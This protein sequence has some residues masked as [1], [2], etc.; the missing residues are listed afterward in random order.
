MADLRNSQ[1]ISYKAT[2]NQISAAATIADTGTQ[3]GV[4]HEGGGRKGRF[5]AVEKAAFVQTL[6]I[7][8]EELPL[9]RRRLAESSE[10]AEAFAAVEQLVSD[11][12][13]GATLLNASRFADIRPSVLVDLAHSLIDH[14]EE[15]AAAIN[16]SLAGILAAHREPQVATAAAPEADELVVPLRAEAAEAPLRAS[17]IGGIPILTTTKTVEPRQVEGGEGQRVSD[18][19][20]IDAS[21]D[22][23]KSP[24]PQL[25]PAAGAA[26]THPPSNTAAIAWAQENRPDLFEQLSRHLAPYTNL[27]TE[28][29]LAVGD[30]HSLVNLVQTTYAAMFASDKLGGIVAGFQSRMTVEPVGNLHLERIE[31]YPA[32]VERGELVHSVPLAPAETINISHKE[33]SVTEREFEDI[34]QDYFEGYSEQG[35]AEKTDIA[36]SQ[37]LAVATRDSPEPRRLALRQLLL[38]HAHD[39]LRLQRDEKRHRVARRTAAT[40]AWR[41]PRRRLP[42]TKKDHKVTF[43]VTSIAGSEDQSVRVISNP[44]TTDT[45]RLDYFQLARKWKVDLL[46]YGLRM[47]YDIVIPEP[48]LRDRHLRRRCQRPGRPRSTGPSPSAFRCPRSITTHSPPTR[49]TISN[50]DQL[51]AQYNATVTAPPAGAKVGQRPQGDGRGQ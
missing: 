6:R 9:L 17:V 26:A 31:M 1:R 11:R 13:P 15:A 41:P 35:V 16:E 14:R 47:T 43:K 38:G 44:S 4:S 42:A 23:T 28:E 27:T 49:T 7:V 24:P 25:V 3:D 48:G 5:R 30:A 18:G 51:A 2:Y 32:G 10:H 12:R 37:R 21:I 29:R 50:Y 8:A 19:F 36:M 33:W 45:M 22:E 46:R 40:T 34:V 39:K 20:S